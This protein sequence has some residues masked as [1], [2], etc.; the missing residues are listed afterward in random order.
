MSFI[1]PIPKLST[2]QHLTSNYHPISLLCE[3]SKVLEL[4]IYS[5]IIRHLEENCPLSDSQLGFRFSHSTV[6]AL[7]SQ[8]MRGL[9]TW[10]L[11]K[12]SVP[13]VLTTEKPLIVF[14]MHP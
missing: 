14:L 8:F 9:N 7:I 2:N 5:L 11:A 6:T 10:S 4:H 3:L 1:V 12:M 13:Y